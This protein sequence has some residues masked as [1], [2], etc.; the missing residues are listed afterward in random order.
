MKNK[1]VPIL[2]SAVI[3]FGLWAYVITVDQPE[4]EKIYYDIPVVLQNESILAERGLMITS[5]R[6]TVTLDLSGTRTNLNQLNESNINVIANVAS[7]VTPGTHELT[8]NVSYPGNIP[9]GSI[10]RKKSSPD[11][12]TLKV[13]NKITKQIP[14]VPNYMG[15]TVPDG[16]VADKENMILDHAM[17]EVSGPESVMDQITKAMILVDLK[18]QTQTIVGEYAYTLC[19]NADEP[20]DSQLV[21]TNV[22]LVNLTLPIQ[23]VKEITLELNVI[24][25]GG[26][27]ALTSVIDI[28]PR[29]IRISGSEALLDDLDTLQL[30]TVD[31]STL[32]GS[33]T[34]NFDIVLP[35]G[36]FNETGI[37]EA[38]VEVKFPNLKVQSFSV[39]NIFLQNVP[40]G[41][42]AELITQVLEVK[43]RGPVALM[44]NITEANITAI[45]D[46]SQASTG[47]D[48]FTVQI[49]LDNEYASVG[50]LNSYS[51]MVALTQ[52]AGGQP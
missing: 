1:I 48:K 11:M 39:N 15:T 7:I 36:V 3:A 30:G 27:T 50:A 16:L 21:T 10:V 45:V 22:E 43:L 37:S 5:E 24:E 35:E 19:N 26:A 29:T 13:E 33:T 52:T 4:S 14:V 18:D 51:V 49:L 28:Q 40:E 42:A 2:L 41:M 12:I 6:P 8:Y 17:I 31:L 9:S 20:V 38:V 25:G 23:R 46:L 47:T 44:E 34:L 32:E